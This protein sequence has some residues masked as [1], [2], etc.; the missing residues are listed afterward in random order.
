MRVTRTPAADLA[1]DDTID[2]NPPLTWLRENADGPVDGITLAIDIA[3]FDYA[4]I[5][6]IDNK[7][8]DVTGEP[9]VVIR[10]TIYDI[11]VPAALAIPRITD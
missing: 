7:G 10:N 5:T 2:L 3:A 6:A 11:A 8:H 9:V 4:T 1:V